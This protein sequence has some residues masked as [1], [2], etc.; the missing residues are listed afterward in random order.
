MSGAKTSRGLLVNAARVGAMSGMCAY[1]QGILRA[2]AGMGLG[3]VAALVAG[4]VEVPAGVERVEA[5]KGLVMQGVSSWRRSV[6]GWADSRRQAERFREWHV[7]STTH[8]GLAGHGRQVLTIHD[9]RPARWPD[10]WVQG[11]YFRHYL[12]RAA[13]AADGVLTV[14]ETAK[15]AILMECGVD[16]ARVFVVPNVVKVAEAVEEFAAESSYLLMVNAGYR[17][18]NAAEVLERHALWSGRYRLKILAA[19]GK[20]KNELREMAGRMGIAER[21]DFLPRV[22]D[23]ELAGLYKGAAALVY[24]SL[25]EGFGLP[26]LEAMR[27]GAPVIASDIEVFREVLGGGATFVRLGDGAS[28]EKAL[29]EIGDARRVERGREI[30]AGYTQE[31]MAV[32]LKSALTAIWPEQF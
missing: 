23:A 25:T 4:E 3:R 32:A 2:V 22:T 18:K 9:L 17:H 29:A 21:V 11:A 28:W 10:S 1:T 24:P 6:M 27:L 14:S 20:C 5:S 7:L 13:R 15:R 30:A 12:P 31:R 26:P 16:A 19:E 8:L